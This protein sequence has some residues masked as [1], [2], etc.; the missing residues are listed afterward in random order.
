ML[1]TNM[2]QPYPPGRKN[3]LDSMQEY[4]EEKQ[5]VKLVTVVPS[6]V[7]N[8]SVHIMNIEFIMKNQVV[9]RIGSMLDKCTNIHTKAEF[10][11]LKEKM[12]V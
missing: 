1:L 6:G 2:M 5:Y 11:Q 9:S 3:I 8:G 7:R 10:K 4:I 12:S